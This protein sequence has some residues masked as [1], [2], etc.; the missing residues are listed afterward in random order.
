[1]TTFAVFAN[2]TFWGAFEAESAEYAIKLAA[3]QHGTDG[4]TSGMTAKPLDQC[5]KKD[6]AA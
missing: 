3:D 6:L 5:A 1:M 4:D 2:G